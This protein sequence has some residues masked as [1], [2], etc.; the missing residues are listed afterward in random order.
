VLLKRQQLSWFGM[1]FGKE[2]E[3]GGREREIGGKWG[4]EI[5]EAISGV[6]LDGSDGWA[7][8]WG[9]ACAAVGDGQAGRQA[10]L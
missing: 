9:A 7:M 2:V 1:E 6:S 8:G 5:E 4:E 10:V 3:E